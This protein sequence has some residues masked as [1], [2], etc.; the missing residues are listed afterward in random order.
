M[1]D[2][3][4]ETTHTEYV[5][6]GS[7]K[8]KEEIKWGCEHTPLAEKEVKNTHKSGPFFPPFFKKNTLF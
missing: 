1:A 6:T 8:R 4:H 5:H 7:L 3:S 2:S